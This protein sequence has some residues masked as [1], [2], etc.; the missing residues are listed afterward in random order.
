M[1]NWNKNENLMDLRD[2]WVVIFFCDVVNGWKKW[3]KWEIRE[4]MKHDIF[5]NHRKNE[6]RDFLSFFPHFS[7]VSKQS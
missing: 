1:E 6:K 2:C 3:E 4:W 7:L 5:S